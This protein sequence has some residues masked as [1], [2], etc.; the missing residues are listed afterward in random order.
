MHN[1]VHIFAYADARTADWHDSEQT[2]THTYTWNQ[3]KRIEG[4]TTLQTVSSLRFLSGNNK[5]EKIR[6]HRRIPKIKANF[7]EIV[8]D[9]IPAPGRWK[10]EQIICSRKQNQTLDRVKYVR[11]LGP[12]F[13]PVHFASKEDCEHRLNL[14]FGVTSKWLRKRLNMRCVDRE[15][16]EMLPSAHL[17]KSYEDCQCVSNC[18]ET[19]LAVDSPNLK[20]TNEFI[21]SF[22][23]FYFGDRRSYRMVSRTQIV[24]AITQAQLVW[25]IREI[26]YTNTIRWHCIRHSRVPSTMAKTL[27]W[28]KMPVSCLT[29]LCLKVSCANL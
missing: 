29:Y 14:F 18:S 28:T 24:A 7:N 21:F 23:L 2:Q 27:A 25:T 12:I 1:F 10:K 9:F 17:I 13:F 3:V 19:T 22:I 11:W 20:C 8:Y 6:Q 26:E 4:I 5:N 15:N 16:V